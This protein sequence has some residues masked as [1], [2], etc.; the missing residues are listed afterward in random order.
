LATNDI[1]I[2]GGSDPKKSLQVQM[3]VTAVVPR[4]LTPKRGGTKL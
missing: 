3:S 2:S 4:S 1:R